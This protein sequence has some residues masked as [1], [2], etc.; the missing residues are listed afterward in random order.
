MQ[1]LN[2]KLIDIFS[3]DVKRIKYNELLEYSEIVQ[4]LINNGEK[5]QH[6]NI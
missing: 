3:D 1:A 4:E 5:E 2:N 6:I